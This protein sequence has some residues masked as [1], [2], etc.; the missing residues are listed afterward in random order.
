MDW[1]Q[2]KFDISICVYVVCMFVRVY[3][4]LYITIVSSHL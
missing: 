4:G 1:T 3:G 2:A